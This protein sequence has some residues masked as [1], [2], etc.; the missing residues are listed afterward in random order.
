MRGMLARA[1]AVVTG[2]VVVLLALLFAWLRNS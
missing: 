1:L 2:I